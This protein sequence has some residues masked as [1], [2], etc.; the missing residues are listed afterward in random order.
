MEKC[1]K[2][3]A[4]YVATLKAVS[5]IHQHGHWTT[6]GDNFYGSHLLFERLYKASLE[7]LDGAAE[8]FIGILG[9][10][11]LD[12]KLQTELLNKILNKYSRLE[13]S[14]AEMSLAAEKDFIKLGS[15]AYE[16]FEAEGHM[17]LG[18]DDFLMATSSKSEEAVYLLQQTLEENS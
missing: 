17:T 8:K 10:A 15:D 4:L 2:V 7:S 12:Y 11:C 14:S 5:L 18:L 16:C 1:E 9:P 3:A 13:D 6:N